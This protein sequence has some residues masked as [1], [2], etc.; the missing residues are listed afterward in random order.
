MTDGSMDDTKLLFWVLVSAGI[1][2]FLPVVIC[3]FRKH[4][5]TGFVFLFNLLLGWTG[6]IWVGLLAYSMFSKAFS[7]KDSGFR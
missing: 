3:H 2:Y 7:E 1:F 6:I 5:K 4:H